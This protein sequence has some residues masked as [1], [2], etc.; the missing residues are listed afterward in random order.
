MNYEKS[1]MLTFCFMRSILSTWSVSQK[2]GLPKL[3]LTAVTS[4][5]NTDAIGNTTG[6]NSLNK[7]FEMKTKS[8]SHVILHYKY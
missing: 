3:L 4:D 5:E 6:R 2:N 8:V 1:E 7:T